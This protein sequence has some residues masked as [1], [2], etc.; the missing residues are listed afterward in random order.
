MAAVARLLRHGS[1][2]SE[3]GAS[4]NPG[5]VQLHPTG[6][7]SISARAQCGEHARH[8]SGHGEDPPQAYFR[9]KPAPLAKLI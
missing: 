1:T 3:V 5:A 6:L 9:T 7:L 4:E 2:F 8:F